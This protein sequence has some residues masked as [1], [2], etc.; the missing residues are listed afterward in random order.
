MALAGNVDDVAQL[1]AIQQMW[2]QIGVRLKI[3]Q[4][5]SASRL[6]RFRATDYQM[7]T[8]LWTNDINDPSQIT[9]YFAY[10]PT[11]QSNR[12][13]WQNKEVD[14]LFEQSQSETD[15]AKRAALYKKLQEIYIAEAPIVFLLNV[16]YPVATS[17][18]V[19]DF[20]QIPLGN[21]IF[22]ETYIDA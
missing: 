16:P 17:A 2:S 5:E 7:R 1:S 18:K 10:F 11:I 15:V 20:V 4:L 9:S 13:G 3:E 22:V 12:S 21:N 19:K 8:S 14:A 6:A